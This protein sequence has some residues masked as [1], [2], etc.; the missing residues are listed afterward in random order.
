M[1]ALRR[2]WDAMQNPPTRIGDGDAV[3][4]AGGASAEDASERADARKARGARTLKARLAEVLIPTRHPATGNW[5]FDA[6]VTGLNLANASIGPEGGYVFWPRR[7]TAGATRTGRGC[8]TGELR[9]LNLEFNSI[10]DEGVVAIADALSPRRVAADE[11]ATPASGV[12]AA[13]SDFD[14]RAMGVQR[15]ASRSQPQLL[16]R[17]S[18]G[19][20]GVGARDPKPRRS[21]R[22]VDVPRRHRQPLAVP[23]PH[24]PRGSARARRGDPPA[25]L[26]GDGRARVQPDAAVAQRRAEPTRR[27]RTRARR[28]SVRPGPRRR[29]R[30][31]IRARVRATARQH[32]HLSLAGGP[33]GARRSVFAAQKP[34]RRVGVRARVID[35]PPRQRVT[36]RGGRARRGQNHRA[37]ARGRGRRR[38][39]VPVQP[40]RAQPLQDGPRRRG[41]RRRWRRRSRRVCVCDG[42]WVHNPRLRELHLVCVCVWAPRG[43]ARWRAPSR[44]GGAAT[45][46]ISTPRC[47]CWTSGITLRAPREWRRR[48]PPSRPCRTN[49]GR[50]R[51]TKETERT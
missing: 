35:A 41:A 38:L 47:G 4:G 32:E 10:G 5:T 33:V 45:R 39:G 43:R 37:E 2:Q 46:G 13:A 34:R 7:C 14:L 15:R 25:T 23:Q 20:G 16:R 6:R 50:T 40:S 29:R 28:A 8:S 27:R 19:R 48:P 21:R 18:R 3:P 22:T 17:R 36:R 9:S 24:R 49:R 31:D 30:M 1:R 44:R 12:S 26:A 11:F 42:R 51:L